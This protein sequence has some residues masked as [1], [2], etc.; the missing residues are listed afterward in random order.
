MTVAI[1]TFV[2]LGMLVLV[3]LGLRLIDTGGGP[4]AVIAQAWPLAALAGSAALVLDRGT[5]AVILAVPYAA[6]TVSLAVAAA[7]R[8]WRRRSFAPARWPC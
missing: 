6:V 4:V 3:P 8:L 2:A 1:G 7:E 5:T